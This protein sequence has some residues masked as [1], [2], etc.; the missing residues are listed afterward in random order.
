MTSFSL[1]VESLPAPVRGQDADPRPLE[2]QQVLLVHGLASTG[3]ATWGQ[4]RWVAHLA[5]AGAHLHL[6]TLPLHVHTALG[7]HDPQMRPVSPERIKQAG[8]LPALAEQLASYCQH[9]GSPVH[10]V[11]YSLGARLCWQLAA[12]SPHLVQ[13]VTFGGMPMSLHTESLHQALQSPHED[14]LPA[15]L[16]PVLRNSPMPTQQ[17]IEFVSYPPFVASN[18]DDLPSLTCPVLAFAGSEDTIAA[19]LARL[20]ALNEQGQHTSLEIAGRDHISTLTSG[21][22]RKAALNFIARHKVS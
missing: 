22:A 7:E 15:G 5:R 16:L 1:T 18:S 20:S 21:Q 17:L 8:L 3:A 9:L 12:A 19:P 2:G 14:A 6:V 11:G 13:S 10:L 4:T